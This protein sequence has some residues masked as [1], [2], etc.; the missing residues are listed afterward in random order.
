MVT[1][2]INASKPQSC[3]DNS[4]V[5]QVGYD[6]TMNETDI[7]DLSSGR[8]FRVPRLPPYSKDGLYSP[9]LVSIGPFHYGKEELQ[10]MEKSK[11]EAVRRMLKRIQKSSPHVSM[12]SIVEQHILVQEKKIRKFYGEYIPLT[13]IELAWMVTRDACFVYEFIVNYIKVNRNAQHSYETEGCQFEYVQCFYEEE[14]G[15]FKWKYDAVFDADVQNPMRERLM[16]D[17][18][19][20]ENQ[21]PLWILKDLLK[22]QMGSAEAA[23]QKVE[24]LMNMLLW[25]A[26]RHEFFMWKPKISYDMYCKSHVLEVVYRS[27]VGSDFS[28][29]ADA[30]LLDLPP[31]SQNHRRICYGKSISGRLC[32]P[33]LFFSSSNKIPCNAADMVYLKLPTASELVRG[34]VKI[35]AVLFKDIK[36]AVGQ[37]RTRSLEYCSAIRWIRFDEKTST[38]Y[39]PQFKVTLELYSVVGSIIAMEVGVRG[40]G[41]KPMTQ[42]ALLMDELIDNEEDVAVLRNAEVINNFVGG[43]QQLAALFNL[44]KGVAHVRG[45]KAIDE[46]RI[47]LHKYTR[48]KYKKLWSEFVNAYFS[49]PWLVAGSM[50]AVLLIVM[51]VAQ[52]LCLFVSCNPYS[53]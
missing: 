35:K 18:L 49:K 34:G 19:Q 40:Y 17:I 39:L 30:E 51:T 8:I 14:V 53:H 37:D 41:T 50:A 6:L 25:R 16:T 29:F 46:V 42:F 47:G 22:F 38:L 2:E 10:G 3:S 9:H 13:S 28:S 23:K 44:G 45:C 31:S 7:P 52:D 26:G 24:N 12:K 1:A 36:S 20:F 5:I 48:R 27:M 21:I 4:C 33:S 43:N 11:S 32:N 15:A